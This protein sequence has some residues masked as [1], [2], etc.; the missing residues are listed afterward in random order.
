MER[1]RQVALDREKA[2]SRLTQRLKSRNPNHLALP[3]IYQNSPP[4]TLVPPIPHEIITPML[5]SEIYNDSNLPPLPPYPK[6]NIYDKN[7]NIIYDHD[8]PEPPSPDM[9]VT[10]LEIEQK[11]TDFLNTNPNPNIIST[12]PPTKTLCISKILYS[13]FSGGSNTIEGE[14]ERERDV[15]SLLFV[16]HS[17]YKF[18][19]KIACDSIR[20]K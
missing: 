16:T 10:V 1:D 4:K 20:E 13:L 17:Q 12:I 11:K 6:L 5:S 9:P 19:Y 15:L 8:P 14:R 7:I 18:A 2:R 3:P